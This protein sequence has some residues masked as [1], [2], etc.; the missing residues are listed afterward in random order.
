VCTDQ[1]IVIVVSNDGDG[2]GRI[3][4]VEILSDNG[5][6][7]IVYDSASHEILP[8]GQHSWTVDWMWIRN[9]DRTLIVRVVDATGVE[10]VDTVVVDLD[11]P[12]V[13]ATL[14]VQGAPLLET[15]PTE[16]LVDVQLAS[17]DALVQQANLSVYVPRSRFV[18]SSPTARVLGTQ[19]GIAIDTI[20]RAEQRNDSV[21]AI[22]PMSS[23]PW[24][25]KVVF[26]G[27]FLWQDPQTFS[28]AVTVDTTQCFDGA[29]DEVVDLALTP[30]GSGARVVRL[31]GRPSIRATVL[32][33]PV[34]DNLLLRLETEAPTS[35]RIAVETLTGQSFTLV[36][37]F[38]LQ[39]G[40]EHCNFSCSGWASGVYRVLVQGSSGETDCK[41]IIVN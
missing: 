35:V 18:L 24:T 14:T 12:K 37:G 21:R 26:A 8:G 2:T 17:S 30:C 27:M 22:L 3:D 25:Y 36:E 7:H 15:G 29:A 32:S 5:R 1:P 9:S 39:K 38:S 40:V 4:T 41:V 13:Q 31:Q 11:V 16:L 20:V 23:G 34:R 28:I 19:R 33:I 6:R 10:L